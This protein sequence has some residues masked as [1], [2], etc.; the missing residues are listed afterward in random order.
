MRSSRD[1]V[2]TPGL[3]AV[4]G[5]AST[6]KTPQDRSDESAPLKILKPGTSEGGV[7]L[8]YGGARYYD[9]SEGFEPS[10]PADSPGP[11]EALP[12][13]RFHSNGIW[14]NL[15]HG[16]QHRLEYVQSVDHTDYYHR[17]NSG[18]W[19]N[20]TG[21]HPQGGSEC[22]RE[23]YAPQRGP[24]DWPL[25]PVQILPYPGSYHTGPTGLHSSLEPTLYQNRR[26]SEYGYPHKQASSVPCHGGYRDV[27]GYHRETDG[28]GS[29]HGQQR[30]SGGCYRGHSYFGYHQGAGSN[31]SKQENMR[32]SYT[33]NP[34]NTGP[35]WPIHSITQAHRR[36]QDKMKALIPRGLG[37]ANKGGDGPRIRLSRPLHLAAPQ[38]VSNNIQQRLVENVLSI[39]DDEALPAGFRN[40]HDGSSGPSED[41]LS[42]LTAHPL[43]PAEPG[44]ARKGEPHLRPDALAGIQIGSNRLRR[45]RLIARVD[46]SKKAP[47]KPKEYAV[48]K[49]IDF[50]E[51]GGPRQRTPYPADTLTELE[52]RDVIRTKPKVDSDEESRSVTRPHL[53]K[54]ESAK[55]MVEG[56]KED[57]L[58]RLGIKTK[59]AKD[60]EEFGCV[61]FTQREKKAISRREHSEG[62]PSS[63]QD[64]G[65]E[66]IEKWMHQTGGDDDGAGNHQTEQEKLRAE[67]NGHRANMTT[68]A[69]HAAA[70]PSMK[71]RLMH[72]KERAFRS[73][74][75]LRRKPKFGDDM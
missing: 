24:Y 58:S 49:S 32:P 5:R 9:Y 52:Y 71:E 43:S 51:A 34:Q 73:K 72:L 4:L 42:D 38:P 41:G 7:G 36:V 68:A 61:P 2:T 75:D 57:M 26:N 11:V 27:R 66:R 23:Y 13:G 67:A 8:Q 69:G 15:S 31:Y 40:L 14:R 21:P 39:D 18:T 56:A 28:N 10:A 33:Y 45:P 30:E 74:P 46:S 3:E 63:H 65:R 62:T 17:L 25:K 12:D 53:H 6:N 35:Q 44:S 16:P 54:W 47:T 29:H 55:A 64:P 50:Q 37:Q 60:A 1:R 22:S 20:F 19:H 48:P 70:C 59:K